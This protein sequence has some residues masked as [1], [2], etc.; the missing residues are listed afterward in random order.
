MRL[1]TVRLI[2]MALLII[3]SSLILIASSC[4]PPSLPPTTSGGGFFIETEFLSATGSIVPVPV[5]N[6]TTG[7]TWL[8]DV[9]GFTAVGDPSSFTNT[10]NAAAIGVSLNG[11]VPA[12]W[13]VSWIAGGP[14]QCVGAPDDPILGHFQSNPQRATEVICFD[15][16]GSGSGTVRG[17]QDFT[18]SPSPLYTDGSSGG[19]ATISGQGFSS[20]YGMPL[21]QYYDM[22]GNLVNQANADA[23]ASD[24]TWISAS[25]PDLSQ[26]QLGSYVGFLYNKNASGSYTYL[27][28][29]S[30]TVLNPPP[31]GGGGPCPTNPCMPQN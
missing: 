17:S 22:S 26:L 31:S 29:A 28:T 18:F 24:G 23:V 3:L 4:G 20:Q 11:R 15:R 1:N 21:L 19:T 6:V 25:V 10:T 30:V 7:W 2:V 12:M 9:P 16:T 5:P 27:G 8:N 14:A 13:A